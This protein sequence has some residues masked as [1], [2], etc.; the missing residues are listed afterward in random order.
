[1]FSQVRSEEIRK[2]RGVKDSTKQ[3]MAWPD[4]WSF[5]GSW[6]KER[7][8]E[9]FRNMSWMLSFTVGNTS[10]KYMYTQPLMIRPPNV[11]KEN[12]MFSIDSSNAQPCIISIFYSWGVCEM[13][14]FENYSADQGFF[15]LIY[16]PMD[17]LPPLCC[18]LFGVLVKVKPVENSLM[19]NRDY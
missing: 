2:C 17:L 18:S 3:R 15:Y 12:S 5:P 14:I 11:L 1:M 7:I 13:K 4:Y 6:P 9:W 10:P 8:Y 19:G 16:S